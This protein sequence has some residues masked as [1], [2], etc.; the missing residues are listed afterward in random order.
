MTRANQFSNHPRASVLDHLP[1]G[2]LRGRIHHP[3][4]PALSSAFG[5]HTDFITAAIAGAA[6]QLAEDPA[7]GAEHRSHKALSAADAVPQG[8]PHAMSD[9]L[10]VLDFAAMDREPSKNQVTLGRIRG[11]NGKDQRD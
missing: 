1:S 8:C 6:A 4:D 7:T 2:I 3:A 9:C 10:T 5:P 11:L